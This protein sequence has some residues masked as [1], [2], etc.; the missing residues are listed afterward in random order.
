MYSTNKDGWGRRWAERGMMGSRRGRRVRMYW[1]LEGQVCSVLV[2]RNKE[3]ILVGDEVNP[4][5]R[6]AE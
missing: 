3:D 4:G 1:I 6:V 5:G 2:K